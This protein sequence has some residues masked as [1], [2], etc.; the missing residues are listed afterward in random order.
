MFTGIITGVGRIV[1]IHDLGRSLHHG[2][3]LTIEAHAGDDSGEHNCLFS[4]VKRVNRQE[5]QQKSSQ[6]KVSG[7]DVTLEKLR[8][9]QGDKPQS[10]CLEWCIAA[11][12]S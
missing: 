4:Q 1:A 2:K 6:S 9:N 10:V 8:V 11:D 12:F 5:A 3:R 7:S